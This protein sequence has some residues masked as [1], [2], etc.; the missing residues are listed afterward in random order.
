MDKETAKQ[1][2]EKL[3][4]EF[5]EYGKEE[6]NDK[7]ENQIKSEFIDPL[8]EALGWNM[9]KDAEREERILKGRADY[10]LRIGN[11]EVLVI[12]AKKT[13]VSLMEEEGR[14]AVSYA[15]HRKIKFAVLT[16]FKEIRVYHALSNIKNIDRNL[17][18]KEGNYFRL[19]VSDFMSKFD[20]LWLLS[21]E[22]FDKQ[23]I[24][25]LLSAKD[26]K[27]N[28]PIDES[29]LADLLKIR[30]WLSKELKAKKMPLDQEKIDEIVQIMIDRLIFIRSVEDRGLEP[31]NYLKSLEADVRQQAVKLQLFPYLLEKFAEFNKKYDSK[32]FEPS[33]L[34]KEGAFSDDVLRKVI[35]VLYFGVEGNQERYMFDIIP[36]DLFGSIY[37]QYLGTILAGTG[38]RIKLDSSSGKRKKMGI[39]YTPSYIVNY[40]VRN[41]V[42]EYIKDK[43]IDE[44]LQVR[45]VDPACGSG[46]FLTRAFQEVCNKV[47]ELLKDGKRSEK[48]IAFKSYSNRLGL[49]QKIA[50]MSNCIYGVDLDEKAAEL[51]KLNLLLKL[52]DGEGQDSKKLIL[53]HLGNIKC[54][55]SLIDDPKISDRAFNWH[56]QFK[57]VF[58]NGGFDVVI[59][60]PP[61]GAKLGVDEK[62]YLDSKIIK[63][64]SQD[65]ANYFIA[66]SLSL[67]KQ[68]GNLGFIAPK[69]VSYVPSSQAIR[70]EIIKNKVKRIIDVSEAFGKDVQ[71][72]QLILILS[73]GN[74]DY[75]DFISGF[76]ADNEFNEKISPKEILSKERL[77]MWINNENFKIIK[78][79]LD[80]SI[81]LKEIAD[82]RRGLG[83]NKDVSSEK[84][85]FV[86]LKGQNVQRYFLE[87][88]NYIS[89]NKIG[90]DYK[91]LLVP[92]IIAQEIVGRYGK[93]L[94]GNF[95]NVQLKA[96][97]DLDNSLT[98]DTVVNIFNIKDYDMKFVLGLINSKTMSWFFHMYFYN[99]SQI[100]VHFGNEYVRN[101]PI[102]KSINQKQQQKM[103][104]LVNQMLE[105][106][107]K[108]HDE[109]ISG[110]EK[111]RL[112]QLIDNI[113]Y[114]I[115]EEV[116]KLYGITKEE[117]KIIEE[118]L[119]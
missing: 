64:K 40:I 96:M 43:S 42:G 53:P 36:G 46:S 62:E 9:R 10:I 100:T 5:L 67:L 85:D 21:K 110:N 24:N 80:K 65:T 87:G 116:Y 6:L 109:K 27:L 58:S 101:F 82:S 66:K 119:K 70:E 13:S 12:E 88:T 94:F 75:R 79:V 115:D 77:L 41:T 51:A 61:Y 30:E 93:P 23:E 47:E 2:V 45:I 114:E 38:K 39:Y 8:F 103:I 71:Y 117:Q 35:L 60:N 95:R 25:A 91:W 83:C 3:V 59:G 107:K 48:W 54:G 108:Y 52:L 63:D 4:R 97:I 73:K 112:K 98:L 99:K 57:D 1:E 89:K 29:I 69:G 111:D 34:E 74:N 18:R 37:E 17:L 20:L 44:I 105:L 55:N 102:P 26:E 113:D 86:C 90:Q 15:Y 68:N 31:L 22:S 118:S 19:N 28:K 11:R 33:L 106:Q 76:F 92:K 7:S 84:K 16:N 72:E 32:L 78:K 49:S 14:Q 50:I 81:K 56:A 104:A